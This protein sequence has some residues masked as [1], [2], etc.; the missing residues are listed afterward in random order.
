MGKKEYVSFKMSSELGRRMSAFLELLRSTSAHKQGRHILS[1]CT[2][3][4]HCIMFSVLH[5]V[6]CCSCAKLFT[7]VQMYTFYALDTLF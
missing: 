7:I 3:L 2:I 4:Y 6:L 1:K 5:C